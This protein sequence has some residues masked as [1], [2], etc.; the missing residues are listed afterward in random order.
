MGKIKHFKERTDSLVTSRA[1]APDENDGVAVDTGGCGIPRIGGKS[2]VDYG[3]GNAAFYHDL[4]DANFIQRLVEK[5]KGVDTVRRDCIIQDTMKKLDLVVEEKLK[6]EL[7]TQQRLKKRKRAKN[8]FLQQEMIERCVKAI[9]QKKKKKIIK[10]ARL[11]SATTSMKRGNSLTDSSC[12][13]DPPT[14]ST[15]STQTDSPQQ[16][17]ILDDLDDLSHIIVSDVSF[18]DGPRMPVIRSG[19]NVTYN[20]GNT[21]DSFV[22]NQNVAPSQLVANM[23]YL[24]ADSVSVGALGSRAH[25]K[26][27]FYEYLKTCHV[28]DSAGNL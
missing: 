27:A 13:T 8:L 4:N 21:L 7:M 18:G 2:P 20:L 16:Q 26:R 28:P 9:S 12:Q 23:G 3:R 25:E 24:S 19:A 1:I 17:P 11:N 22:G 15:A 5:C 14:L 10:S 6:M